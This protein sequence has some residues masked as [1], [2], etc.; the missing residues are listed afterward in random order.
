VAIDAL[1]SG[2]RVADESA[3]EYRVAAF[4]YVVP[5]SGRPIWAGEVTMPGRNMAPAGGMPSLGFSATTQSLDRGGSLVVILVGEP[6]ALGGAGSGE[7]MILGSCVQ[8]F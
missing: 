5:R 6:I 1:P 8:R 3:S 2:F 4:G 7:P